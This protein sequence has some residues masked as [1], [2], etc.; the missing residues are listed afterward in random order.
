MCGKFQRTKEEAA[1]VYLKVIAQYLLGGT[2][3]TH[4]QDS[5][6]SLQDSNHAPPRCKSETFG[7]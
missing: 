7:T 5:R 1:M 2:E 3:K 4:I 6:S